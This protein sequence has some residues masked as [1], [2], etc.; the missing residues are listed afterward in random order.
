MKKINLLLLLSMIY[1]SVLAQNQ[2]I[3]RGT[4]PEKY[5][6]KH[7]YLSTINPYTLSESS[8]K[9]D[10]TYI[11]KGEFIFNNNPLL[12][13]TILYLLQLNDDSS[14][15]IYD[16]QPLYATYSEED[17]FSYFNISGSLLNNELN[18]IST[19]PYQLAKLEAEQAKMKAKK[20]SEN[21]HTFVKENIH[22]SAGKYI[23][24]LYNPLFRE[25]LKNEIESLL[26][27][28]EKQKMNIGKESI[29]KMFNSAK[30]NL[31]TARRLKE[32]DKYLDFESEMLSGGKGKLSTIITSK[33]LTLL[34]FWASWCVPCLKDIPKIINLHKQYKDS[35]L[36]I[37]GI[38]LDHDKDKWKNTIEKLNME[39]VHFIDSNLSNPI[40]KIYEANAIPHTVLIDEYG[41]IVAIGLRGDKLKNKIEEILSK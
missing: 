15:F 26:E 12:T 28:E 33:K 38:S 29:T 25:D 32:G 41:D 24:I 17:S 20:F 5:N 10:S 23:Y 13:D 22:N 31:Y 16:G 1:V 21:V 35:G 2:L 27:D 14:V 30:N 36:Q 37:V 11:D 40:S 19:F 9:I 7:I 3:L 6:G 34:D 39:W 18:A 8:Y 4:V